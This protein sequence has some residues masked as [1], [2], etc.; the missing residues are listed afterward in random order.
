MVKITVFLWL[1]ASALKLLHVLMLWDSKFNCFELRLNPPKNL[2][3]GQPPPCWD[4]VPSLAKNNKGWLPSAHRQDGPHVYYT[5]RS[6][7][8]S[9]WCTC[10]KYYS[11]LGFCRKWLK[12]WF[13][14]YQHPHH[15]EGCFFWWKTHYILGNKI[16]NLNLVLL[17]FVWLS[18]AIFKLTD[19]T[20]LYC[21]VL[22]CTVLYCTVLYCTVLYCTVLYCTVLYCTVRY[23]TVLYCTVLYCTVYSLFAVICA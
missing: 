22:Y 4:R 12:K 9:Q 11:H 17:K 10:K 7:W 20:V 5:K 8:F 23:C 19:C 13:S 16:F 21:T 3:F 18:A 14:V 2:G 6:I 15:I 1:N